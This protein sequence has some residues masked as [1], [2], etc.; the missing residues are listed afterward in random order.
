MCWRISKLVGSLTF[1]SSSPHLE[2][3]AA[4]YACAGQS[5]NFLFDCGL[6]RCLNQGPA[7]MRSVICVTAWLN[8]THPARVMNNLDNWTIWT[9]ATNE[10]NNNYIFNSCW[11]LFTT[12]VALSQLV[13][14]LLFSSPS[15]QDIPVSLLREIHQLFTAHYPCRGADEDCRWWGW[16]M[17][18][19]SARWTPVDL[20]CL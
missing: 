3:H 2:G 8:L 12:F 16:W 14:V 20:E 18:M 19:V 4:I 15:L 6:A 11:A 1:A 13:F 9:L 17:L 5:R 7:A 10:C